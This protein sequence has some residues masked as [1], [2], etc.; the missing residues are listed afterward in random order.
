MKK[1]LVLLL[2][3]VSVTV[4]KA[5]LTDGENISYTLSLG[6]INA[7]KASLVTDKTVYQGTEAYSVSLTAATNKVADKIYRIRDTLTATISPQEEP[8]YFW[9]HSYEGDDIVHETAEFS[10]NGDKYR[11]KLAKRYKDGNIRACDTICKM[12]IYDMVSITIYARHLDI[13]GKK[14]GDRFHFE[15]ADAGVVE[16]ET[17]V[18]LGKQKLKTAGTQYQCLAFS[19]AQPTESNRGKSEN[20]L[21][22]IYVSDDDRR[23]PVGLDIALPFGKAK[24]R[25]ATAY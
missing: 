13:T 23:I 3:C 24:A 5:Q 10:R 6:I 8:L 1:T 21:L 22:K 20:E 17:L 2:L 4:S 7:G 14:P 12:P 19:V 11:G 15:L 18:Y 9:K 25:L 16:Q